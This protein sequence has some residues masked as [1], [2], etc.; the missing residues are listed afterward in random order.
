MSSQVLNQIS[1]ALESVWGT[2]VTPNKS[3]EV[4]FSG[5]LNTKTNP[6]YVEGVKAVIAKE[7]DAYLG[8]AAYDGDY[9]MDLFSNYPGYFFLSAL[10][11]VNSALHAGESVVYDN[12][13][14]EAATKKSLSIEQAYGEDVSRFLGYIASGFKITIK[15]GEIA[16]V[17]F[18]GMAKTR[19]TGN[20]KVAAAFSATE[21]AFNFADFVI[22][23]GGSTL[24]EILSLEFEYKNNVQFL[25]ALNNSHD[26]AFNYIK[27]SEVTCKIEA[28]LDSTTVTELNNYL[29]KT[30]RSLEIIGTGSAIGSAANNTFDLLCPRGIYETGDEKLQ[31]GYNNLSIS[32]KGMY[33]PSTSKLLSLVLTNLISAYS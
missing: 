19:T 17:Q 21:K 1:F 12:T 26:P 3:I 24:T 33:D 11:S 18:P 28:Y 13:F 8:A 6:K 27:P 14:T 31:D 5:G 15:A 29:N 32:F 2:Q 9:E 25:A 7:H 30:E 22:K 20:T 10:G 23:L 4:K 16:S